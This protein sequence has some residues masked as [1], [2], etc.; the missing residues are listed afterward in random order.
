MG[1]PGA[2]APRRAGSRPLR[3][4]R[5]L[6]EFS[7]SKVLPPGGWMTTAQIQIAYGNGRV[8]ERRLNAGVYVLGR[9]EGDIV[10]GDPACSGRHAELS[11][12]KDGVVVTDLGSTNGTY[13]GGARI[14]APH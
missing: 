12:G 5:T 6:V 14:F 10:L 3:L 1:I 9:E 4:T 2:F 7:R 13:A 11:V 8:E